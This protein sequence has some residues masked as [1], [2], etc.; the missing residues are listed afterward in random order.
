MTQ[1][2]KKTNKK[3]FIQDLDNLVEPET[4]AEINNTSNCS[5]PM[6]KN[7]RINDQNDFE[8]ESNDS[9][10]ISI[11]NMKLQGNDENVSIKYKSCVLVPSI[12]ISSQ[13]NKSQNTGCNNDKGKQV[14]YMQL[15]A[16]CN[17]D[18]NTADKSNSSS[19]RESFSMT[20]AS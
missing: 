13:N 16:C 6:I 18:Q 2:M 15:A 3:I 8:A 12:G 10:S 5:S 4:T 7:S 19:R 14:A 1:K 11:S 20:T 9:N 17:D